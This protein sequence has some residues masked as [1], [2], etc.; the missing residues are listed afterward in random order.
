M[1][2]RPTSIR[3]ILERVQRREEQIDIAI[4]QIDD[5]YSGA[6]FEGG[7]LSE[8]PEDAIGAAVSPPVGTLTS[9]GGTETRQSRSDEDLPLSESQLA[10]AAETDVVEVLGE[11]GYEVVE[12]ADAVREAIDLSA[13]EGGVRL[14]G[15]SI[16][17]GEEVS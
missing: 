16:F 12:G 11:A 14:A 3:Y 5:I 1:A 9:Y 6:A 8:L 2:H 4:Q 13:V 15:D 17:P 7:D 10:E